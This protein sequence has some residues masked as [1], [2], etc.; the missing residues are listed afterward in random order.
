MEYD[1]KTFVKLVEEL[2]E[3]K[4]GHAITRSK[5]RAAEYTS[6]VEEER[7]RKK[8]A[9]AE[10]R[11]ENQLAKMTEK[12]VDEQDKNRRLEFRVKK[13]EEELEHALAARKDT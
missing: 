7:N 2:K 6:R 12:L 3:E 4:A 1:E 8:S 11:H 9:E 10:V 5:L 13:A